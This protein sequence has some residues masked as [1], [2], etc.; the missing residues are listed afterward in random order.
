MNKRTNT[1]P[2][3]IVFHGK[4]PDEISRD[5]FFTREKNERNELKKSGKQREERRKKNRQ[6]NNANSINITHGSL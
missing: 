5:N 4:F 2:D 6:R 1:V 3:G